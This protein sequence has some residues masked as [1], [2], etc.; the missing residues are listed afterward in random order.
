[1][2]AHALAHLM[3]A[4]P[5]VMGRSLAARR[6]A[7]VSVTNVFITLYVTVVTVVCG[8]NAMSTP[9]LPEMAHSGSLMTSHEIA[10]S[11]FALLPTSVAKAVTTLFI[12]AA[13]LVASEMIGA[14]LC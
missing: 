5:T 10:R 8:E 2:P 12:S 11:L 4:P 7:T 3:A 13:R 9:S 1:M 6:A 14:R